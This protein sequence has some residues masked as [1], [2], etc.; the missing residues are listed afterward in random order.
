MVKTTQT[1][2]NKYILFSIL[3]VFSIKVHKTKHIFIFS[4]KNQYNLIF[5]IKILKIKVFHKN[6]TKPWRFK[7]MI[8]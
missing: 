7:L 6:E 8:N 2:I 4:H 3:Y 5:S 1:S